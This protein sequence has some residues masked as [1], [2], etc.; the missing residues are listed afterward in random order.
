MHNPQLDTFLVVADAGSFS[1]AA[2]ALYV[3]PS[4]VIQQINMLEHRLQVP[5][6]HRSNKGVVL[7]RQGAYLKNECTEYIKRGKTI[8]E[9]LLS[10]PVSEFSLI[11]GTSQ[12]EKCRVFYDFWVLF[13]QGNTETTVQLRQIDTRFPIPK[14][15][16]FIESLYTGAPWQAGWEYLELGR[17]PVGLAMAKDHP[18]YQKG[19]LTYEDLQE[20]TVVLQRSGENSATLSDLR[21]ALEE[22]GIRT[23]ERSG[24][25]S[26]VVWDASIQKQLLVMPACFQD[27][28][29]DMSIFPMSWDYSISYG[30]FYRPEAS[31]LSISFLRFVRETYEQ[32]PEIMRRITSY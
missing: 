17:T 19:V 5:L 20:Y 25:S 26:D 2:E 28:I 13:S 23:V 18:L 27:V 30:F 12:L 4:A 24:F 21:L 29:L 3:T 14:D 6:F 7:T 9:T 11:L 15:I 1:K 31:A 16:D 10:I 22:H 32:H 8:R